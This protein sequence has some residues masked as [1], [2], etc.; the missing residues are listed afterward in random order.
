M[1]SRIALALAIAAVTT[2]AAAQTNKQ[3]WDEICCKPHIAKTN[4]AVPVAPSEPAQANERA[5]GIATLI[6]YNSRCET[7]PKAAMHVVGLASV[8][9]SKQAIETETVKVLASVQEVG[10][11]LWCAAMK[12]VVQ[13]HPW[14]TALPIGQ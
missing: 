14:E 1:I 10:V 13:A 12:P 3:T 11:E 4:P 2:G 5:G 8:T 6:I 9:V 7:V